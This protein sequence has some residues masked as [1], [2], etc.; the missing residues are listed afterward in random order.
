LQRVAEVGG[1]GQHQLVAGQ[2]VAGLGQHL[3]LQ[4]V[5]GD[6]DFVEGFGGI[7]MG[8][9]GQAGGRERRQGKETHEK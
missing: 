9:E 8:D 7:G 6:D 1:A 3:A 2:R 4:R 5:A